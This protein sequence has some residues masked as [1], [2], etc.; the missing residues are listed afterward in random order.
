MEEY[1]ELCYYCKK[2]GK[3]VEAILEVPTSAGGYKYLCG[4]HIVRELKTALDLE[5]QKEE[6]EEDDEIPF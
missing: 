2:E 6:K 1:K 5:I 4:P 3:E